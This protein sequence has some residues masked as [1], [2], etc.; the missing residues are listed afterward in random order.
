MKSGHFYLDAENCVWC[1]YQ[2]D[3]YEGVASSVCLL[4]DLQGKHKI[5]GSPIKSQIQGAPQ[6]RIVR[7]LRYEEVWEDE[8]Y[9]ARSR[10][11]TKG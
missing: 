6:D 4:S 1:C 2:V 7:E 11:M 3:V 9:H 8:T 10:I 5:D